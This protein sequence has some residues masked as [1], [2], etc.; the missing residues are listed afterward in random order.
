MKWQLV[1]R[2][3]ERKK[4]MQC[5]CGN[6]DHSPF[7]TTQCCC[8]RFRRLQDYLSIFVFVLNHSFHQPKVVWWFV[9]CQLSFDH[10][11]DGF[12]LGFRFG[13]DLGGFFLHTLVQL[14]VIQGIVSLKNQVR[15]LSE[16]NVKRKLKH[17]SGHH[18]HQISQRVWDTVARGYGHTNG[19]CLTV[20]QVKGSLLSCSQ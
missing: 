15:K 20:S 5:L 12:Q 2:K 1:K 13:N 14:A 6:Q 18:H 19:L 7:W 8:L 9:I 11:P 3:K 16:N 17:P 4:R 10:R